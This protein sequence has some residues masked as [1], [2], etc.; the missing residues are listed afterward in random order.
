MPFRAYPQHRTPEAL[1]AKLIEV[2]GDGGRNAEG[3]NVGW[4]CWRCGSGRHM[5]AS[6]PPKQSSLQGHTRTLV[7]VVKPQIT[8][9]TIVGGVAEALLICY[10]DEVGGEGVGPLDP[11]SLS[12]TEISR[13]TRLHQEPKTWYV[14]VERLDSWKGAVGRVVPAPAKITP[15]PPP[16]VPAMTSLSRFQG[17]VPAVVKPSASAVE[18]SARVQ[19][20]TS[21]YK[22]FR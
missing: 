1:F 19:N 18:T 17:L 4:T 6:P 8:S 11:A 14:F 9:P 2:Y 5:T 12:L 7:T 21:L 13:G 10:L 16:V 3:Q 22:K 20:L 15:T